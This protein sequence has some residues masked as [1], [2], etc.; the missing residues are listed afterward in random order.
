MAKVILKLNRAKALRTALRKSTPQVADAARRGLR[1]GGLKLQRQS[2]LSVPV[3]TGNLKGSAFTRDETTSQLR[4][5]IRVGFTAR[6]A[7]YVHEA[8]MSLQGQKRKG[9]T[10]AG[11][12]RKGKYWDPQGRATNKFLERPFRQM[13]KEIIDTVRERVRK[14]ITQ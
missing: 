9:K 3:D 7:L 6:Y 11:K 13:R 4:P 8:P 1:A 14:E 12:S 2:Q 10:P 5:R